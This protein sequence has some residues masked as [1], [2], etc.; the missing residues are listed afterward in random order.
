MQILP[1]LSWIAVIVIVALMGY[2]AGGR[3]L[4]VLV[5]VCFGFLAVFG[6]WTQRDGDAG[7]H[8]RRRRRSAS[9]A[10]LLLGIAAYRWPRFER[11]LT[12]VLDLMQ[13]I[14]VFAYLVPILF[15]FGFG[16]TAAVV[17]TLIYAMP[18]MTRITVAG[19]TLGAVRGRSISAR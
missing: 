3:R 12:P 15:L 9:S 14:P 17:A 7:L 6:Q 2:H 4:A 5:A 16:P 13:T 1:P 8:S 10:A 18:P 11:A 19:A